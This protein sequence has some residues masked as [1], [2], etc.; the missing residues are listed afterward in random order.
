MSITFVYLSNKAYLVA[1]NE[2]KLFLFTSAGFEIEAE[3]AKFLWQKEAHKTA[4][5]G[6]DFS[7][8]IVCRDANFLET[9]FK[10]HPMEHSD[11]NMP[12]D[13]KTSFH[14]DKDKKSFHSF[15]VIDPLSQIKN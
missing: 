14:S 2:I 11:M 8:I 10:F 15:F 13:L 4:T 6:I 3:S 9:D 12:Y 5:D 7:E 1:F